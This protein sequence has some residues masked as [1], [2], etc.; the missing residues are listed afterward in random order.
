[1]IF[2]VS[3]YLSSPYVSTFFFES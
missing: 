2:T 1:M 3:L